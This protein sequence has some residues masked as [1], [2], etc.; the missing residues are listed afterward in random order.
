MERKE[1]TAEDQE[2]VTKN[3]NNAAAGVNDDV[4]LDIWHRENDTIVGV[5][6]K[7]TGKPTG[8]FWKYD[9]N[10]D[11]LD[12]Q[13]E[14]TDSIA[15]ADDDDDTEQSGDADEPTTAESDA[16]G[17]ADENTSSGG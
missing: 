7:S 12:I 10:P 11:A 3:R 4:Q 13:A 9:G 2:Y 14:Y 8:E 16:A 6:D 5:Q 15:P 1:L 17:A